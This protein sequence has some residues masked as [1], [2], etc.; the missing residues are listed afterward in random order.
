MNWNVLVLCV[1]PVGFP[2]CQWVSRGRCL[3]G[4]KRVLSSLFC[5]WAR[6][7]YKLRRNSF[8]PVLKLF[9][10]QNPLSI[11]SQNSLCECPEDSHRYIGSGL[12]DSQLQSSLPVHLLPESLHTPWLLLNVR[13]AP[14][15]SSGF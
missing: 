11:E 2:Q 13:K 3:L 9:A 6:L 14:P 12:T 10:A 1:N 15:D 5:F 8:Y 7:P 4:A